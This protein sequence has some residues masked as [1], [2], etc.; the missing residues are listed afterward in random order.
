MDNTED[1]IG[2]SFLA[3]LDDLSFCDSK[4]ED[5][6][7]SVNYDDL[8]SVSKLQKTQG[9][10]DMMKKVEDKLENKGN[11]SDLGDDNLEYKLI[12]ECNALSADIDSEIVTVHNFIRSHYR[13]KFTELES[14]VP[15]PVDYAQVVK[16]IG[17]ETDLTLVDLQGLLP[18]DSIMAVIASTTS[19]KPLPEENLKKTIDACD[20][21][22]SLD[23]GKNKVLEFLES[24]LGY[25]APNLAVLVGSAV[26]AKLLGT[27]GGLPALVKMPACKVQLLGAEEK[28]LAGLSSA[29]F[30]KQILKK[31][32][33]WQ[34]PLPVRDADHKKKRGGGRISKKKHRY[35]VTN[36]RE[37]VNQIQFGLPE[38]SFLDDRFGEGY[39]MLGPSGSEEVRL[40]IR[41][42]RL[43]AHFTKKFK[44]MHV[45]RSGASTGF[46][47]CQAFTHAQGI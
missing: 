18:S 46:T 42:R 5:M 23:L 33:K 9:Y 17:N 35:G 7:V 34:E 40:P 38:E 6:N 44:D 43:V 45:V 10:L 37:L 2:D 8:E 26:A 27:A 30:R 31:I 22:L 21:I 29:H 12:V 15:H 3:D 4:E 19:G 14:L 20:C 1:I 25:V 11:M 36:T 47:S 28:I 24:I 39:G 16:K 41:W 13:H 32:E